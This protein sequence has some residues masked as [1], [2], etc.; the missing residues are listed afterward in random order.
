[1][2]RPALRYDS[3]IAAQISPK[4]A[5]ANCCHVANR[6]KAILRRI[7]PNTKLIY[8]CLLL[9]STAAD[10]PAAP[11]V[12]AGRRL[13]LTKKYFRSS[14]PERRRTG[15]EFRLWDG[16]VYQ[17]R[18]AEVCQLHFTTDAEYTQPHTQTKVLFFHAHLMADQT[19]LWST[20]GLDQRSSQWSFFHHQ[21]ATNRP[22]NLP[23]SWWPN[24]GRSSQ[25][26]ND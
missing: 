6:K 24:I 1:M 5:T 12:N 4:H 17:P 18:W 3:P 7:L 2:E 20:L 23:S 26:I 11:Y 8:G 16:A 13:A 15:R 19:D 25:I 14:V 21:L 9:L 22:S 10:Q